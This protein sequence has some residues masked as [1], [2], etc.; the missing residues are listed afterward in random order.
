MASF[1]PSLVEFR[2]EYNLQRALKSLT[3]MMAEARGP[4]GQPAFPNEP[5]TP[6]N[7]IIKEYNLH[8]AAA[9]APYDFELDNHVTIEAIKAECNQ[10]NVNFFDVAK[11]QGNRGFYDITY[12]V[13][14][15][16]GQPPNKNPW[17][18]YSRLAAE[19]SVELSKVTFHGDST[20]IVD[21]ATTIPELKRLF[22]DRVYTNEMAKDC[23]VHLVRRYE[24]EQAILLPTQ[25]ANQIATHLL[26]LDSNRVKHTLHRQ[27]QF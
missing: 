9:P 3:D 11:I 7:N 5:G 25:T 20:T 24:P 27:Q 4:N 16:A 26:Q 6:L 18:E 21:W 8:P 17:R 14:P 15:A 19:K 23:L 2:A 13:A 1:N 12:G 10:R 22:L